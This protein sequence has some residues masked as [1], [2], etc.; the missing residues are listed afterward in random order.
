MRYII[1]LL[2][3]FSTGCSP[4]NKIGFIRS[5]NTYPR[6]YILPDELNQR[7][8]SNPNYYIIIDTRPAKVF[9]KAH[10]QNAINYPYPTSRS[11]L[12]QYI[13]SIPQGKPIVFYNEDGKL[14][15]SLSRLMIYQKNPTFFLA[16][17]F[18]LW[19]GNIEGP[20]A[21]NQKIENQRRYDNYHL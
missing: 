11:E 6:I 5:Q 16:Y 10:I 9:E 2:L 3:F 14:P 17:G 8:Y 1:I 21:K 7:L 18:K 20:D 4:R 12:L 15:F 13:S 19:I